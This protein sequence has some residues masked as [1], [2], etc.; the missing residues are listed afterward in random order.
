MSRQTRRGLWTLLCAAPAVV[1]WTSI[2]TSLSLQP[3]SRLWIEGTSTVRS[4]QCQAPTVDATIEATSP[5]VAK[6][7]TSGEKAVQTVELTIPVKSMDCRNGTMNEH[8]MKALKANEH[9]TIVFRLSSYEL[10]E[11]GEDVKVNLTGTLTLGGVEKSIS[12]VA[13]AEN[14]EDGS[15]RVE[16][17]HEL[18]MKEYGLK[19]PTLMMGTMK[20]KELVRVR[21]DL[22]LKA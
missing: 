19:P 21:F 9:P 15:L 18:H 3:K 11:V 8:M 2:N 6:L 17:T 7:V 16:G 5:E 12:I 13:N 22:L 20:V 14:A 10:A 1:A 4:F